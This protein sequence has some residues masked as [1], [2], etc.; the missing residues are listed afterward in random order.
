VSAASL[1]P[2]CGLN[3]F[4]GSVSP[5]SRS[6]AVDAK[7]WKSSHRRLLSAYVETVGGKSDTHSDVSITAFSIMSNNLLREHVPR[8]L[9]YTGRFVRNAEV[10]ICVTVS[11]SSP[12]GRNRQSTRRS[13]SPACLNGQR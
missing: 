12:S 3:T 13:T 5:S 2:V 6:K 7:I 1:F 9:A 4:E 11:S 10:L 8:A